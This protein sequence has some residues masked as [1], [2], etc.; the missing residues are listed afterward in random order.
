MINDIT[1]NLNIINKYS[2]LNDIPVI[3]D[4]YDAVVDHRYGI[5]DNPNYIVNNTEY[6]PSIVAS[7]IYDIPLISY[8]RKKII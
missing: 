1:K 7:I 4:E 6:Y 3:I 2:T 5:H 8:G